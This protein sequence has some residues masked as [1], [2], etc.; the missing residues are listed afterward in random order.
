MAH[1]APEMDAQVRKCTEG[2][3]VQLLTSG[4][5]RI[6][7]GGLDSSGEVPDAV[8]AARVVVALAEPEYVQPLMAC[9]FKSAVV[10]VE[11]VNVDVG[12]DISR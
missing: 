5:V 9:T 4:L 12:P 8:D 2:T 3:K 7:W 6:I 1:E 10:E 11:T